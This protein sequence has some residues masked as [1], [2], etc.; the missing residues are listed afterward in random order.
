MILIWSIIFFAMLIWYCFVSIQVGVR[1][2]S[3]IKDMLDDLKN[4]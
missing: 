3:N 1:G 4:S 2:Y